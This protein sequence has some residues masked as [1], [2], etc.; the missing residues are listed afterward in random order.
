MRHLTLDPR[1]PCV[2]LALLAALCL[3]LSGC[4]GAGGAPSSDP[5]PSGRESAEA[6]GEAKQYLLDEGE[7]PPGWRDATGQQHLGVPQLCGVVL[8]PDRLA[9]ATSK[10][11]SKGFSGPFIIQY[12]FVASDEE[13]AARAVDALVTE[14]STCS[15]FEAGGVTVGVTRINDIEPVGE[16]F[17]ALRATNTDQPD[18]QQDWVVFRNGAHVTVLIG[19]SVAQRPNYADLTAVARTIS[20]KH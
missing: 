12:S 18:S 1:H 15:S 11:F 8:E 14:S 3:V 20:A 17:S 5:T 9:S 4:S 10:R 7:L 16:G 13:A 19:Y 6:G 2:A